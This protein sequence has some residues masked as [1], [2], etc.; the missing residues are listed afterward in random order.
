MVSSA[1]ASWRHF[2]EHASTVNAK[3][4]V[5]ADEPPQYSLKYQLPE[6]LELVSFV[7]HRLCDCQGHQDGVLLQLEVLWPQKNSALLGSP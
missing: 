4:H 3:G 7:S 1:E 6:H 5:Q 2:F